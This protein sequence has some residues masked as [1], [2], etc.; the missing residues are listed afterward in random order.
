LRRLTSKTIEHLRKVCDFPDTGSRYHIIR[1]IS[2]GRDGILY[3][4]DDATLCR[5]VALKVLNV[6]DPAEGPQPDD[7]AII[8]RLTH[9]GIA[10]VYDAG[11]LPDGRTYCTFR[12]VAGRRLDLHRKSMESMSERLRVFQKICDAVSFA[13]SQG[14]IHRRLD[15]V[16]VLVGPYGEVFVTGWR[17][18]QVAEGG[19]NVQVDVLALVNMLRFLIEPGAPRALQAACMRHY[20]SV[21]RLAA[22]ITAY[23]D[24]PSLFVLVKNWVRRVL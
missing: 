21:G 14:V 7:V 11:R 18:A 3:E 17:H 2:R 9:P 15:P 12:N 13:H 19:G 20:K 8:A 5:R 24:R 6:E 23:L 22:E 16:S 10:P 4:A 1:E